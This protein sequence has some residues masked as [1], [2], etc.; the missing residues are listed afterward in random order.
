MYIDLTLFSILW[1]PVI[2]AL[3]RSIHALLPFVCMPFCM[4]HMYMYVVCWAPKRNCSK[5]ALLF[6]E[7]MLKTSRRHQ[8][9][10]EC[11][12]TL[13]TILLK[14]PLSYI[15]SF[16]PQRRRRVRGRGRGWRSP[17]WA[18][19]GGGGKLSLWRFGHPNDLFFCPPEGVKIMPN[20]SSTPRRLPDIIEKSLIGGIHAT[21]EHE[22]LIKRQVSDW[23]QRMK[24]YWYFST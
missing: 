17:G 8:K 2:I 11:W 14:A 15:Y 1:R 5:L 10:V 18:S 3:H 4:W 24:I 20:F 6:N 7:D 12:S 19:Q 22:V 23:P 9:L 16:T 21:R 13:S